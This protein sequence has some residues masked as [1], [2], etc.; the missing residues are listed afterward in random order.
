MRI[1]DIKVIG[2]IGSPYSRKLRGVLR[3]RRIPHV[4]VNQGH[5]ESIGLPAPKV[6]LLPTV[7]MPDGKGGDVAKIDTTP[8]IRE[9]EAM[10][11]SRGV[12]PDSP[13]M[14]FL[15]ALLEDYADEWLT[16]AMFHYRWAYAPDIAK[17]QS[18]LPRWFS[19]DQSDDRLVA[20]GKAFGERQ[21]ERL[22]V[23]GSSDVTRPVIED[24]YRRLLELLDARL[25]E[26]RFIFGERPAVSDF[27]VYGQLTQLTGFDPTPAALALEV[28]PRVSAWVDLMDDLSGVEPDDGWDA[29][30]ALPDTVR[31]LFREIGRVYVPFLLANARALDS[32]TD[33][34]ECKIDGRRWEQRSFPYQ[35]RCLVALRQGYA[36]LDPRARE[37]VDEALADTGCM[38]LFSD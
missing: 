7:I 38:A 8:L 13:A 18:M 27:A 5:R 31:A 26:S 28:A 6:A 29:V 14:A 22:W 25:T 37:F 24:S 21:I 33:R 12:V 2:A 32:G 15:D 20:A 16:K 1:D 4:W 30:Q 9:F 36:A 34:V 10:F 17:A 19:T 3:Y 23:V 35:G 11:T